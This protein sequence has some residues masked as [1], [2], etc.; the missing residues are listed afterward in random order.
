MESK[1]DISYGVVPL[2]KNND[3][4]EVLVIHQIS[5]RGDDFWIFPKGHA[6]ARESGEAAALRELEEETGISE[7]V[8]ESRKIFP[9]SYSFT[10]ENVRINKTVEYRMGYCS[11]KRTVITQPHEVKEI[12]WCDFD[13]AD[14]L[15]THQNSKDVLAD[16]EKFLG[17][18]SEEGV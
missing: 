16:V 6:E 17:Q 18:L 14:A 10:H 7:C 8:L 15:L 13:T 12:R 5:Y 2:Y 1:D 4:W 9:V 3:T 11:S